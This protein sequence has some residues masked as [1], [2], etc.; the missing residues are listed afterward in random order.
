[1]KTIKYILGFLFLGLQLFAQNEF[2]VNTYTDS[3]QRDPQID[4]DNSGNYVIVWTSLNQISV[5][6][7]DE[8]YLQKFNS[9]NQKIGSEELVNSVTEKN[10]EKPAI[11]MNGNGM[12]VITWASYSDFN[13]IYDIK[14]RIYKNNQPI[15]PE[16]LVNTT[17]AYT[18]TNPDV[19]IDNNGNFVITWDS[20][21]QDGSNKGIYAQ[22][23][24]SN[25]NK[26]GAE[27]LV[28]TST[29]LSQE[30]PVIKKY[31]DGGF[32]IIWESWK[33]DIATPAGYGIYGKIYNAGGSLVKDEFKLNNYVNDYQWFG[34]VLVYPSKEFVV[35]WCSWEQDGDDG[36]I[37]MQ[38]FN[39]DA[40]PVGG[41][42]LVNKTTAYYQ[43]LPKIKALDNG[44][45]AVVWSSWKQDGDRE[46][47]YTQFFDSNLNKISFECRVND[48]SASYQWEP[49]FIP[50]SGNTILAVYSSWGI[51]NNDYE[52][53]GR[54]FEP[55]YPQAIIQP[56]SY[57][58]TTGVNTSKIVVN[59][60]DS[61]LVTNNNYEITYTTT[62]TKKAKAD[63]VNTTTGATVVSNFPI[64]NGEG[65]FYLTPQFEG[66]AV[67][68]IPEFDFALN[69]NNSAFTNVSG[70]NITFQLLAAAGTVVL[71]PIDCKL[72]WGNTDT[73]STGRY[74]FPLDTAY[75]NSGVREVQ[76]PFY[77]INQTDNQRM[78]V[79]ISEPTA[80]K[81]KRWDPGETIVLLTPVQYQTSF[82]NFHAQIKT[83]KP[84]GNIIYPNVG[85]EQTILTYRPIKTGDKI[86]FTANKSLITTDV[87]DNTISPDKFELKQNYPNPFNPS[88]TIS[89]NIPQDGKVKLLVYNILGEKIS[90]LIDDY[91]LKGNYKIMFNGSNFASGVYIYALQYGN[92]ILTRKMMMV[93]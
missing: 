45:I 47:V 37:Y 43:W 52:I 20:W 41:E 60:I 23:F 63:I 24:D 13:S 44:N 33:Q 1:M 4:K 7:A 36:G 30:R 76:L 79:Y 5:N 72:I 56:G 78:R 64:E 82:P 42:I 59:V 54:L 34:D 49:V 15:G 84:T 85:D 6:N 75:S 21:Y 14:A 51:A 28:N 77:V 55:T 29:L 67:E 17:T 65:I 69:L 16:F 57:Q 10:Q 26:Q 38:K 35:V 89:F 71:A 19:A 22:M 86:N 61:T 27:F 3:T 9:A 90:T 25:G 66:L 87:K 58:Q 39:A 8:I 18:Q 83:F 92:K 11:A 48:Y 91:K 12:F 53:V 74:A 70:T 50:K 93:K 73:L 2:I 68:F 40:N 31:D 80:T 62:G 88:T 81:N 46:G 32:I